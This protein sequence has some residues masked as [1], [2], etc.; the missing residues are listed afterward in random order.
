[1]IEHQRNCERSGRYVE[2]E[3][4]RKRVLELKSKDDQKK[5]DQIR[6]KHGNEVFYYKKIKIL[7]VINN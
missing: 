6:N 1:M 3:M 4:A 5:K 2:A 7:F